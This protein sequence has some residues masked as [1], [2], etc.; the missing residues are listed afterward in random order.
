VQELLP[1]LK[2]QGKQIL[3]ATSGPGNVSELCGSVFERQPGD[4]FTFI[5]YRGS[6]IA[7]RRGR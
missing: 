1:Y 4:S 5:A 3:M 2:Q 7:G 6:P